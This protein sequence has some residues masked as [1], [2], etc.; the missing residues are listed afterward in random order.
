[1]KKQE[2]KGGDTR[3][4]IRYKKVWRRKSAKFIN[5]EIVVFENA[6][7]YRAGKTGTEEEGNRVFS[8]EGIWLP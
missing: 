8:E 1:M 5:E 2:R 3:K 7:G 6:R 4:K